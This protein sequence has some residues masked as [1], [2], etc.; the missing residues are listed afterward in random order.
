MKNIR[1]FIWDFDGTLFDTYPVIIEDLNLALR[2]F[3]FGCDFPEQ[4]EQLETMLS[5]LR[6]Y[7]VG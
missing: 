6:K 2:E 5:I 7:A 3:G 1:H 4:K